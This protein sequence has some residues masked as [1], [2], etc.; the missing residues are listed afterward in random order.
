MD[1]ASLHTAETIHL[2]GFR[3][4]WALWWKGLLFLL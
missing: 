2:R 4:I 3:R 1:Y